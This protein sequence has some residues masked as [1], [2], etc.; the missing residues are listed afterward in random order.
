MKFNF[1]KLL[2]TKTLAITFVLLILLGNFMLVPRLF[3]RP[4]SAE[5]G[6]VFNILIYLSIIQSFIL[7]GI[8][9]W[10]SYFTGEDD[11]DDC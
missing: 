6:L 9:A 11:S 5:V 1:R 10:K 3:G 2:I 4:L 8:V 7:V